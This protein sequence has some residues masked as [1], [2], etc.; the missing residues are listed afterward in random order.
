MGRIGIR[1]L[2]RHYVESLEQAGGRVH[3]VNVEQ[4]VREACDRAQRLCVEYCGEAPRVEIHVTP[5]AD[6]PF[7]YTCTTWCSSSSR[8]RCARPWSTTALERSQAANR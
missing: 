2:V 8:T 6:M 5:R 4:I 1:M 3:R 7:M